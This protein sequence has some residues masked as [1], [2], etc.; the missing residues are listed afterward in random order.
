MFALLMFAK[1]AVLYSLNARFV[2]AQ[3]GFPWVLRGVQIPKLFVVRPET[4]VFITNRLK[5][6]LPLS[7]TLILLMLGRLFS[8]NRKFAALAE[9]PPHSLTPSGLHPNCMHLPRLVTPLNLRQ[10][11]QGAPFG[12]TL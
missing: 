3:Y 11:K 4:G 5:T 7:P 2:R 6:R 12:G 10:V 9:S 1:N 8:T